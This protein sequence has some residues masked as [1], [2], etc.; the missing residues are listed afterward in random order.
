MEIVKEASKIDDKFDQVE[1]D[2]EDK[3]MMI[4]ATATELSDNNNQSDRLV[5]F[6]NNNQAINIREE[7]S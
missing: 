1:E 7:V 3:P 2:R 5:M 4:E 6:D